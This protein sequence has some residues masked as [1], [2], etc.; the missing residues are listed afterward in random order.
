MS[1]HQIE[2]INLDLGDS[3]QWQTSQFDLET[4]EKYKQLAIEELTAQGVSFPIELTLAVPTEN[5]NACSA[6]ETFAGSNPS[7][8]NRL[9]D[10]NLCRVYFVILL[11]ATPG[12]VR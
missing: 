7:F 2:R 4:A 11:P 5:E 6:G 10:G 9:C 12:M 3:A 1:R 8:R